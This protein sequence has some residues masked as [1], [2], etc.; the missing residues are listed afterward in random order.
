MT[1]SP[2][3]AISIVT[4]NSA[5]Y[6]RQCLQHV[7][8]Q[9]VPGLEVVILDNASTDGTPNI[10]REYETQARVIYNQRNN[11][12][13][14]GQNQA[15]RATTAP[16]VLTLNPDVRLSP[17]FLSEAIAAG[18]KDKAIGT[19]CGKLLTMQADFEIPTDAHFDSTGIYFMPN[20]RHLDRGSHEPDRGQFDRAEYV[21]GAT[22]AAALYRRAMIDDVACNGEFFDEDFFAY[23]ED[24][25]LAWRAQ[26]LGWKCLYTPS[27]VAWHVR[28][29][30]PSN[31]ESV[32]AVL[33]MHSVK[34]RFLM[35]M[36]N[37]TLGLYARFGLAMTIR[38]CAVL[39]SCLLREHSSLRA[40]PLIAKA[41]PRTLRKRRDLMRRRRV[42]N[43]YVVSWFAYTPVSFPAALAARTRS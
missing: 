12:F 41:L 4:F 43:G 3:A 38:D 28:H 24:A 42:T 22:G 35:R 7:F 16:W 33:N 23:R 6:I 5:R 11:G 34:N 20:M 10:L 13:A 25:D 30:L 40:F 31:R 9:S 15:I 37:A 36:K 29:V 39:A 21:F 27:A 19:V 14:G 8:A 2:A 1:Q 17:T 18:E 26:W 32:P